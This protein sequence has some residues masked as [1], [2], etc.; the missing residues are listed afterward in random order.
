MATARN[1]RAP[2]TVPAIAAMDVPLAGSPVDEGDEVGGSVFVATVRVEEV[3]VV[4]V[5]AAVVEGDA[6]LRQVVVSV[7]PTVLISEQPP[8]RPWASNMVNINDVPC[9]TLASQLKLRGPT[10][11][12]KIMDVPPGT[13]AWSNSSQLKKLLSGRKQ[14][15]YDSDRLLSAYI[16]AKCVWS[17]NE[18]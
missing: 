16:V 4:V 17:E 11:G 8:V 15:H 18:T 1:T 3:E 7:I 13:V 6:V 5:V 9:A 12:V 10:G 2:I 14:P